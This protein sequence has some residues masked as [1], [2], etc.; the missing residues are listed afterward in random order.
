MKDGVGW[1]DLAKDGD[2]RLAS[3]DTV[4]NLRFA[5]S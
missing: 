3:L 4:M 5:I 2:K 1:I